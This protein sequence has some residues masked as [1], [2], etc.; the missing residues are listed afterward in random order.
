VK[1]GGTPPDGQAAW[2]HVPRAACSFLER[3]V[4]SELEQSIEEQA[5]KPRSASVDGV[6]VEQH[7]L[8]DQIAA[9]RY[10][11]EKG[12]ARLSPMA[13]LRSHFVKLVP[14]GSV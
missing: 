5:A 1:A 9:D 14:P 11:G 12:A 6:S 13:R 10:L 2:G 3:G 8:A 4:A 7:P